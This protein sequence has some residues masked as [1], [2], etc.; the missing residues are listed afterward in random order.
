M[1][2]RQPAGEVFGDLSVSLNAIDRMTARVQIE[3]ESVKN[4]AEMTGSHPTANEG[5][6]K[7]I[8]DHL[9]HLNPTVLKRLPSFLLPQGFGKENSRIRF[10]GSTSA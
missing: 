8:G 3:N 6:S 7:N 2:R 10:A 5:T 1:P 9:P 4:Y